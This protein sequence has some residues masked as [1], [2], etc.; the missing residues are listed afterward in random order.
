MFSLLPALFISI[1]REEEGGGRRRA[2]LAC[3]AH[4]IKQILC[5]DSIVFLGGEFGLRLGC[6]W[7]AL[8]LRLGCIWVALGYLFA[9]FGSGHS[10]VVEYFL[11][12]YFLGTD[13]RRR[14]CSTNWV[15]CHLGKMNDDGGFVSVDGA[16]ETI[17]L[18]CREK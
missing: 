6:I 1:R 14:P 8:G 3:A 13:V 12:E 4:Q 9:V 18:T 5:K 10:S 2:A 17:A 15:T 7:A 16:D 11:V